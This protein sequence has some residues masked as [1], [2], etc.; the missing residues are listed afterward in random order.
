MLVVPVCALLH[1]GF[2]G[3]KVPTEFRFDQTDL[4]RFEMTALYQFNGSKVGKGNMVFGV[5]RKRTQSKGRL[6]GERNDFFQQTCSSCV[7]EAL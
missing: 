7:V 5:R 4:I 3:S 6:L 1:R 2:Q